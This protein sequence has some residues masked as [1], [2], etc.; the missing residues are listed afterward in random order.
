[1]LLAAAP[2]HPAA[3]AVGTW[4]PTA[5][6][7]NIQALA[8]APGQPG[9]VYASVREQGLFRST[10]AGATWTAVDQ[11]LFDACFPIA[12]DV[13]LI[14]AVLQQPGTLYA[15]TFGGLKKT[16]DGGAT[17][18]VP[19]DIKLGGLLDLTLVPGVPDHLL[20]A[21]TVNAFDPPGQC[22]S[23]GLTG[24]VRSD[25]G[26]A[27]WSNPVVDQILAVALDP[28]NVSR[29]FTL[30][31]QGEPRIRL[32][33]DGGTTGTLLP[34]LPS[35]TYPGGPDTLRLDPTTTPSTLFVRD[36]GIPGQAAGTIYR[37]A[38]GSGG[39]GGSPFWTLAT[40]G[41]PA[42]A[43]I[44][45]LVTDPAVA[46]RLYAATDSGV[47]VSN[48]RGGTWTE[49]GGGNPPAVAAL[50][51][52][53]RP[54]GLLYAGTSQ[55]VYVLDRGGCVATAT[56]SC[57]NAARFRVQVSFQVPGGGSA[58]AHSWTVTGDTSA[59]WFFDPANLELLVKVL[60]G[61]AI[62]D[63]FWVFSGGLSNLEYTVTVTDGYTGAVK[64][65]HNPPGQ[66]S[67]FAD[68]SAFP[69]SR[70]RLREAR[71]AAA[72][73]EAGRVSGPA[74]LRA[75]HSSLAGQA[76]ARALPDTAADTSGCTPGATSV[77]LGAAR[78]RVE[79]AYQAPGLGGAAQGVALT[80]D[81]GAWWFLDLEN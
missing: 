14:A 50:A 52:E 45:D 54:Q 81:T 23:G 10:D 6:Q 27:T 37:A 75:A 57:L 9:I 17:W 69:V 5:L 35:S 48:D 59:F 3:A 26:G 67:S 7:G 4:S 34:Q 21:V 25:D 76:A 13:F 33:E 22:L 31:W 51:L 72:G 43:P 39:S 64:S 28:V 68:T 46:G 55:G 32:S 19:Y 70:R 40:T 78:F 42:P 2:A 58:S 24:L 15:S 18:R 36:P 61:S 38:P 65:Y 30:V 63:S 12:P 66:L 62:N 16:T 80:A 29:V 41:L 71:S 74:G 73:A 77:C 1:L 47:F 49:S 53:P 60:D 79:V 20:A 11:G 8:V 44:S 56:E